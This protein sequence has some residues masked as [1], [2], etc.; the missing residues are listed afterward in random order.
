MP[1]TGDMEK[2]LFGG[3]KEEYLSYFSP[4]FKINTFEK[5]HN[6]ITPRQGNE[7]FGIFQKK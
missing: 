4:F 3:S 5:C 2:R 1:L 6:S 7:L